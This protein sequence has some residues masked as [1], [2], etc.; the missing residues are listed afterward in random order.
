MTTPSPL[1]T[2]RSGF[3]KVKGVSQQILTEWLVLLA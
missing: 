3:I 1:A 2:E